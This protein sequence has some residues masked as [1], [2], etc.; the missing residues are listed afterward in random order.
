MVIKCELDVTLFIFTVAD[1]LMDWRVRIF[2]ILDCSVD[3]CLRRQN[4]S[5]VNS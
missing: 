2:A 5:F 1:W 3:L 4:N